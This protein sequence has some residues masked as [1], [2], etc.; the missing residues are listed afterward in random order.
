MILAMRSALGLL[1]LAG[2]LVH[3]IGG[4]GW[5][6]VAGAGTRREHAWRGTVEALR[7]GVDAL[8]AAALALHD[9]RHANLLPG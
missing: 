5:A 9:T 8:V 1:F 7:L 4:L 6:R 3:G 2:A